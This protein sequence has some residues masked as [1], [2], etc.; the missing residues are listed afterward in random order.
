M[1]ALEKQNLDEGGYLVLEHF[2]SAD[3]L[4][5]LRERVEELFA[6][7]GDH[8]GSEFKQEPQ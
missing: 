6:E 3:L 4:E 8:A 1:T 7:E 5:G 2:M